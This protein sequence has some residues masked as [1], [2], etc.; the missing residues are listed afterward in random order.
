MIE[1]ILGYKTLLFN[2]TTITYVFSPAMNKSLHAAFIK[3]CPSEGD[4]LFYSYYDGIIARK[5]LPMQFIFTCPNR[6]KSEGAKFRLSFPIIRLCTSLYPLGLHFELFLW[7]KF[8]SSLHGLLFFFFLMVTLHLVT[9]NDTVQETIT[10][11]YF[12][13][14]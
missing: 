13:T 14:Q 12:F 7:W 3:I 10:F 11:R 5:M 8:T 1:Q 6:W 4:P 9:D 2:T